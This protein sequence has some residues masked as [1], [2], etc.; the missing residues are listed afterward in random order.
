MLRI[1]QK[2]TSIL[3]Y[4]SKF[5]C[6]STKLYKTEFLVIRPDLNYPQKHSQPGT[7]KTYRLSL[8]LFKN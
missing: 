2:I 8:N 1:P 4:V 3:K 6:E 5:I 7:R